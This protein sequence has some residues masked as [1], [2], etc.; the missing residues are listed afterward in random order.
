[1]H[2]RARDREGR[3][4]SPATS[5]AVKVRVFQS[6]RGELLVYIDSLEV[7]AA[8]QHPSGIPKLVLSV[9]GGRA[10]YLDEKGEWSRG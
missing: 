8:C 3:A 4:V 1:M 5:D 2:D 9:D 6:P 10:V 7:P